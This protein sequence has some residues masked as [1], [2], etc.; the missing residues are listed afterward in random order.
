M[1][2]KIRTAVSLIH[3]P[4]FVAIK[5]WI[6]RT[7]G[8][9]TLLFLSF[10]VGVCGATVAIVVKNLLY[11]TNY[12]LSTAFPEAQVNYYYLAFPLVGI[13]LTV[14]FVKFAVK[15][16]IN[17][18]V[19]IVLNAISNY[20]GKLRPHNIY[21][22]MVAASVTVGFG[23]SVGLE[24]PIVLTGSAVGSNLARLFNLQ[25]KQTILLLACGSSAAMAAI[26]KAPVA[27]IVFAIEVLMIDLTASTAVPLLISAATGTILSL[28]FLGEDVMLTNTPVTPFRLYNVWIY[29]VLGMAAGLVSVYFLRAS[30]LVDRIFSK[31]KRQW[32]RLL[33]GSV[34]LGGLI[35]IF[36]V[37]YGEGYESIGMLTRGDTVGLFKNS[38]LFSFME[39]DFEF[40]FLF[41][42]GIV[43]IKV[44]A[45]AITTASGGVGGVFAP[46]LFVGAFLGFLLSQML[47]HYFGFSLPVTNCV[48]AGM[49]GLLAGVMHAPLTG[50]FLIAELTAGYGLLIPLMVTSPIAY[51]TSRIFEKHSVYTRTLAERG[52]LK[53]HNKDKFAVR[54]IDFMNLLDK[55]VSTVPLSATLRQFV[56]VIAGSKRNI[57]VVLDDNKKFVGLLLMDDHRDVIFKPQLYD[58]YY[59]RDLLYVPDVVVFDTDTAEQMVSK[60]QQTKNFNLPVITRDGNYLGFLSRARVLD[61]YKDVIAEESDD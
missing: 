40:F 52:R 45:T 46:S 47:N 8:R 59:V 12:L 23:G 21:S 22:S 54:K 2:S 49:A 31:L 4:R 30:R 28:L 48:L 53:T 7:L 17:H 34:L 10:F 55:N 15:D 27:S 19:S 38:P 57:F 51:I 26:F 35:F 50:I 44:I 32:L 5:N 43:L 6:T 1:Q 58:S 11:Y 3:H 37:F 41:L 56:D 36:P 33:I 39:S 16:N 29:I 60:F 61:V 18:G 14:I 25:P 24:A 42:A 20:N 13:I 9:N